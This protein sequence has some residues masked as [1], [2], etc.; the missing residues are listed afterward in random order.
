M[1]VVLK[2]NASTSIPLG[3]KCVDPKFWFT[4]HNDS[5]NTPPYPYIVHEQIALKRMV[6][7][8]F[9][10]QPQSFIK[11]LDIVMLG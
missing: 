8:D 3:P 11:S 5:L 7:A 1:R 4:A 9:K 2:L 10:N 6:I